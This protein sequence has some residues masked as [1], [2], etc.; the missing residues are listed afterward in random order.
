LRSYDRVLTKTNWW[1][2]GGNQRR[3]YALNASF[4]TIGPPLLFTQIVI[5]KTAPGQ[6]RGSRPMSDQDTVRVWKQQEIDRPED[7]SEQ[8]DDEPRGQ[9]PRARST[10]DRGSASSNA[11]ASHVPAVGCRKGLSIRTAELLSHRRRE[12]RPSS[13]QIPPLGRDGSKRQGRRRHHWNSPTL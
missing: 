12:K 13:D 11:P 7:V 3:G 9:A 8:S 2:Q 6:A 10:R 4:M 1:C 5:F